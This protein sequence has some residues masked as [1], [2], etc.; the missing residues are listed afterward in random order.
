MPFVE[1]NDVVQTFATCSADQA[2]AERV[3]SAALGAASSAH[4]DSW[5]IARRPQRKR[6]GVAIMHHRPMQLLPR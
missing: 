1:W 5:A 3:G 6:N 4:A 2:L